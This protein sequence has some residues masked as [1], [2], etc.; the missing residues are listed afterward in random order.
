MAG[1]TNVYVHVSVSVY[2]CI[3]VQVYVHVHVHVYVY[4]NV[5]AYVDVYVYHSRFHISR[6]ARLWPSHMSHPAVGRMKPASWHQTTNQGRK[7]RAIF[8]AYRFWMLNG[9]RTTVKKTK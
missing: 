7:E 8:A 1:I 5:Y 9:Y 4:V 2:V 3:Y 6:S